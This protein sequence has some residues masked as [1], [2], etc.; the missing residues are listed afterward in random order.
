MSR[1]FEIDRYPYDEKTKL[2]LKPSITIEPGVTVLVGCN[3]AG[4]STLLKMIKNAISDD[5]IPF[6]SFDNSIEGHSA[7]ASA[8][9]SQNF[10][11]A[12]T[13]MCSSEG[14]Q[15]IVN[16]NYFAQSIGDMV[17]TNTNAKEL[18]ILLD[19]IDSGLSI[20][21]IISLKEHLFNLVLDDVHSKEPNKQIYFIVS[22]NS[23]EMCYGYNCLDV[24]QCK[25]R[26]FK[27]YD[28]FKNFILKSE[29]R[30]SIRD[31]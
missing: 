6:V 16:M 10:I 30:K 19:G 14:E 24:Q 25:Y 5:N 2:F 1:T 26:T 17:R 13:L 31:N 21:N 9:A 29:E 4:K 23:Y 18:W 11:K 8:L 22:A 27:S 12:S 20:S 3:G 15:I 28:A 7:K